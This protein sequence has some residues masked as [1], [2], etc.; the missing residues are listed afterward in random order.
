MRQLFAICYFADQLF[1]PVVKLK[2]HTLIVLCIFLTYNENYKKQLLKVS[3]FLHNNMLKMY[4]RKIN[5]RGILGEMRK[6]HKI[7]ILR[8][9]LVTR[10]HDRHYISYMIFAFIPFKSTY[11]KTRKNIY[12]NKV[13]EELEDSKLI[14]LHLQITAKCVL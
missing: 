7:F 14:F 10:W 12:M 9:F 5:C 8:F 3:S 2:I 4:I 13:E 11:Y 1:N 6:V